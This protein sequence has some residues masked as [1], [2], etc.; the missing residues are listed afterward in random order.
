MHTDVN[1]P[2]SLRDR[3]IGLG[4]RSIHKS[5][6]PELKNRLAELERFRSMLDQSSDIIFLVNFPDF[7]IV[8][9]TSP[10]QTHLGWTQDELIGT[11]FWDLLPEE[12]R[13][14]EKKLLGPIWHASQQ[15][16]I[17]SSLVRD[18]L[19]MEFV[20]S[21][22]S[23]E[24]QQFVIIV[25]QEISKR[26]RAEQQI[27]RQL[28]ALDT[29][30]RIDNM[31][32]ANL[33]LSDLLHGVLC[34]VREALKADGA[35]IFVFDSPGTLKCI[36]R[37]GEPDNDEHSA[38]LISSNQIPALEY[39]QRIIITGNQPYPDK[40][41]AVK[42]RIAKH[43]FVSYAAEPLSSRGQIKGVFEVYYRQPLNETEDWSILLSR[44]SSQVTVAVDKSQMFNNLQD[45]YADLNKA[46]DETLEG[47]A[48][49]LELR[50][51]ETASHSLQVVEMTVRLA[52]AVGINAEEL[53]HV[54]RGAFLHDIGKMAI[55]DAILLKPGSLTDD[56][57]VI[58][59]QHPV[60]AYQMLSGISYLHP[61]L[62]IPYRHHEKWDGSG[63]PQ[64]LAG[65]AIPLAARVFSVVD[66]W[67][68]LTSNRVYRIAWPEKDAL[69]YIQD[70]AGTQFDPKVVK[71]FVELL[72]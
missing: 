67:Q 42:N 17:F 32:T 34:E 12:E 66:V 9:V 33:P 11:S 30:H 10:V 22:V 47:W 59:R 54:R 41:N 38:L 65:E 52:H 35:A 64:G 62:D 57:W 39:G 40:L 49:A 58:M 63:Y 72:K 2:D 60:L 37:C 55:P 7:V 48:A 50:E 26:L 1:D 53:I 68:A 21:P 45:A 31:I 5:Y 27:Q 29:L 19:P 44:L 14:R 23:F 43:G 70:H 25:T 8:D 56:E 4:E 71:A 36:A 20:C 13:E 3:I 28:F 6:Y 46:Y 69:K 18:R 51:K 16:E 61:A 24:G 15:R